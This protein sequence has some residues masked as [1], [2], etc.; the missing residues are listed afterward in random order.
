MRCDHL[1][2]ALDHWK[3]S[4]IEL[5]RDKARSLKVVPMLTDEWTPEH[6]DTYARLL[7][8][9][10]ED[11]LKSGEV[12]SRARGVNYFEDVGDGDLFL[13]PDTGIMPESGSGTR[14][15]A[16]SEIAG[17]I[18]KSPT[19]MLLIYQHRSR[20]KDGI[21]AKLEALGCAEGLKECH[22]FAY[23]SGAVSMVVISQKERIGEALRRL[24][25]ALGPVAKK[26]IIRWPDAEK[27]ERTSAALSTGSRNTKNT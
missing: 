5:V 2:D 24:E 9:T 15:L 18:Q 4:V 19:R 25:A 7:R 12:F 8:L 26:R 22:M 11:V 14:Y 1:G 27:A 13:D 10:R 17:L 23:D 20:E 6:V 16:P 21:P 3:G